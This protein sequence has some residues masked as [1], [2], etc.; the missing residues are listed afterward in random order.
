VNFARAGDPNGA[1][2]PTWPRYSDKI[3][4]RALILGD[5]RGLERTP[6][7]ERLALYDALYAKQLSAR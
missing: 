4:G 5:P 1:G 7:P 2:L 6:D 3:T